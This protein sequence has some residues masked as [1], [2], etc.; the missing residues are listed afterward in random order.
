ME[1]NT[2]EDVFLFKS[3]L[4]NMN[5]FETESDLSSVVSNSKRIKGQLFDVSYTSIFNDGADCLFFSDFSLN[6]NILQ[7]ITVELSKGDTTKIFSF[8]ESSKILKF[9]N[10]NIS[11]TF[12][13][14][15]KLCLSNSQ[16]LPVKVENDQFN[17]SKESKYEINDSE[18]DTQITIIYHSSF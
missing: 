17:I 18:N 4:K 15:N 6:E 10:M 2:G 14:E 1:I 3:H 13:I 5:Y 16:L 12:D 7:Y 11:Y 9:K 8:P